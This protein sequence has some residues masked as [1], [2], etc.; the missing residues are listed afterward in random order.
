MNWNYQDDL[1]LRAYLREREAHSEVMGAPGLYAGGELIARWRENVT[2]APE[3]RS[4]EQ[5]RSLLLGVSG[6]EWAHRALIA[7]VAA[8]HWK[9]KVAE[10]RAE[11]A[12]LERRLV[13]AVLAVFALAV[14]CLGLAWRV[15]WR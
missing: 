7:E 15:W 9:A 12:H 8:E 13:W 2:S 11:N 6:K 3:G 4:S 14:A 1:M 10:E 5:D